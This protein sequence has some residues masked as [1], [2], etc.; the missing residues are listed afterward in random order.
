MKESPEFELCQISEKKPDVLDK[1]AAERKG[2]ENAERARQASRLAE[3]FKELTGEESIGFRPNGLAVELRLGYP[4]NPGAAGL[5]T[6]FHKY[7]SN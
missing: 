6:A 1:L 2:K 7:A 4:F 3:E 5:S